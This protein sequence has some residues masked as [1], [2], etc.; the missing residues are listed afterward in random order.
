M[1]LYVQNVWDVYPEVTRSPKIHCQELLE[2]WESDMLA[3]YATPVIVSADSADTELNGLSGAPFASLWF[4]L[5][6]LGEEDGF[7]WI[8]KDQ[9]LV[10]SIQVAV[11]PS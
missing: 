11:L 10:K 4:F 9:S 1:Y 2:G 7:P 3:T 5:R 6:L 8:E